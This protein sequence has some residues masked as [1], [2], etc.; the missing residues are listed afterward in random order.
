MSRL[1]I[2]VAIVSVEGSGVSSDVSSSFV[3]ISSSFSGPS[4]G[5]LISTGCH[6]TIGLSRVL[7]VVVYHVIANRLSIGRSV[8]TPSG[9]H[10]GV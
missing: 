2:G 6:G 7:A 4:R 9:G 3:S 10:R 1:T 5:T 8:M